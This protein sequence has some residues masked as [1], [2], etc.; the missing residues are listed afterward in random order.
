MNSFGRKEI[1]ITVL[2]LALVTLAYT[3]TSQPKSNINETPDTIESCSK[4]DDK[5]EKSFCIADYAEIKDSIGICDR[6]H[7]NYPEIKAFC[8]ARIE[9]DREKC[10]K[11]N[12]DSLVQ[13]C[14]ESVEMKEKWEEEAG[15]TDG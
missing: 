4:L 15:D 7:P 9:V 13:S 5:L 2:V 3:I 11:L 12:D 6:I 10:E 14:L 8:K 1:R